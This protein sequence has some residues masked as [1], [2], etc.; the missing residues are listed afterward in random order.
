MKQLSISSLVANPSL[1]STNFE[2][3]DWNAVDSS[4]ERRFNA[5]LPKVKF[6]VKEGLIDGDANYL[7][8]MNVALFEGGTYDEAHISNRSALNTGKYLG[9]FCF[10][11]WGFIEGGQAFFT[12]IDKSK[13]NEA[14]QEVKYEYENWKEMKNSLKND[15]EIRAIVRQHFNPAGVKADAEAQK[16]IEAE[17]ESQGIIDEVAEVEAIVE[18][19]AI[20]E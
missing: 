6:L 18:I 20:A 12:I 3:Y 7:W 11:T 13:S 10:Q 16:A 14:E 19:E 2:F 4:L 15:E 1:A 5:I 9:C 8:N 17:V